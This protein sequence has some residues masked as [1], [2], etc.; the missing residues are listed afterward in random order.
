MRSPRVLSLTRVAYGTGSG[1]TYS[2]LN[3]QYVTKVSGLIATPIT[4]F[5]EP[6][7]V[8]RDGSYFTFGPYVYNS[9]LTELF[10]VGTTR[11]TVAT[12]PIDSSNYVRMSTPV[13]TALTTAPSDDSRPL[14]D[15]VNFQTG[16]VKQLAVATENPRFTLLGTTRYNISPRTMV[17]DA[18]YVAYI[19]TISGLTVI[20]LTP[21]GVPTPAIA[22]GTTAIVNAA[23]GT[24]NIQPGTFININGTAHAT[25]PPHA[26]L[27]AVP[28]L[29]PGFP[30]QWIQ[31]EQLLD[32][33]LAIWRFEVL[34]S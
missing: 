28:Q 21:N 23:E 4:G 26:V 13:L 2:A 5:Y 27:A 19:I 18:N 22:S 10:N 34:A 9:S 25:R 30:A 7:G 20:P 3:D 16:A 11:N 15:L 1:Y 29:L 8:A 24:Q 33:A 14:I 12:Y 31:V 6:L 17:V 32:R